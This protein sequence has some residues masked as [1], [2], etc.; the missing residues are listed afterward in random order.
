MSGVQFQPL[1]LQ[2]IPCQAIIKA[3]L[4]ALNLKNTAPYT[5]LRAMSVSFKITDAETDTPL[6][7]LIIWTV[8]GSVYPIPFTNGMVTIPSTGSHGGMRLLRKPDV[9]TDRFWFP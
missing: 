9:W 8:Y 5:S 3:L 1:F 7:G 2:T 4:I 6:D